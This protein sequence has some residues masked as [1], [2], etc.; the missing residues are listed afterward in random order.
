MQRYPR[1]SA[2]RSRT[3]AASSAGTQGN[4]LHAHGGWILLHEGV[5]YWY[6]ENRPA[7]GFY[8]EVGVVV[9]SSS[10]LVNGD[11]EGVALAVS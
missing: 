10:D 9:Y 4:I 6:G 5:Y 3:W 2:I 1:A 8:T 11:D 7:R